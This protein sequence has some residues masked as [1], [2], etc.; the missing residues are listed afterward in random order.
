M[1]QRFQFSWRTKIVAALGVAVFASGLADMR[2]PS[3]GAQVDAPA[4]RAS[5]QTLVGQ[6]FPPVPVSMSVRHAFDEERWLTD[7]D[8]ARGKPVVLT[9]FATWCSVC[10]LDWPA[11]SELADA[12]IEI[13][14]VAYRDSADGVREMIE[15]GRHPFRDVWLDQRAELGLALRVDGLPETLV[16]NGDGI[17]AAHH[18]GPLEP[19]VLETV[20]LPALR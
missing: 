11:L 2:P 19:G 10:Q 9:F 15:A 5:Q 3:P 4:W 12:G 8:V 14:G 7:A 1:M 13:V 20:I 18:R 17:I 16:I 6:R